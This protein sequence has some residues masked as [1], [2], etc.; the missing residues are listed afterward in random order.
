ML[1]D[2]HENDAA[3]CAKEIPSG[4]SDC[5][6]RNYWRSDYSHSVDEEEHL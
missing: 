5:N 2:A 3:V 4:D 6:D 1:C